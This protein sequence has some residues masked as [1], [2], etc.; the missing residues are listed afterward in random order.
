MRYSKEEWFK[1][2]GERAK[3]L[4]NG[5]GKV[6]FTVGQPASLNFGDWGTSI[7]VYGRMADRMD[8]EGEKPGAVKA[9]CAICW[10]RMSL[11]DTQDGQLVARQIKVPAK[12]YDGQPWVWPDGEKKGQP[13]LQ[14]V[15]VCYWCA[16]ITT[17]LSDGQYL[18]VDILPR[19]ERWLE[20][21]PPEDEGEVAS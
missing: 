15:A 8:D 12:S 3:S 17:K 4:I 13:R 11:D 20:N 6:L 16:R 18:P 10:K 19:F 2:K 9:H 5:E 7:L 14:P 1:I 21:H